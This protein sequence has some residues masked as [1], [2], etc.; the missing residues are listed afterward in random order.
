MSQENVELVRSIYADWERGEFDRA[1]WAHPEIEFVSVDGPDPGVWRG[2]GEMAANFRA[3]LRLWKGFRLAADEY[4]SHG[5]QSVIVLDHYSGQGKTSGL[6]L[7]QIQARG[8]WVFQIRDG[9]V[10]RMTRYLDRDRAL[11]EL[12]LEE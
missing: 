2:L 3:W 1:D 8:A 10:V 7:G 11:A 4:R 12:G 6:D 9:K 5:S